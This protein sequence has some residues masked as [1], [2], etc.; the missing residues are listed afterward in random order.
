MRLADH[1]ADAGMELPVV[2]QISWNSPFYWLRAGWRDFKANPLPSLAYG[3][4]FGLGGDLIILALLG[5]PYL[6]TVAVSGLF[7]IAPL[8]AA[9]LY[10]LSRRSARGEKILFIDS[11]R[12]FRRNSQSLA[13]FG[14]LIALLVLVW[15]RLSAIAFSLLGSAGD[16]NT[17]LFLGHVFF[18]GEHTRFVFAWLG[19]GGILALFVF[20]LSVVSVPMMLDRDSDFVTAMLSS[21]YAFMHNPGPLLLWGCII[22]LLTLLGF[23]TLLFGLLLIM[24]ILGHASWHAYRE[25]VE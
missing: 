6:V 9:G 2:R 1:I 12:C 23:A 3:I 5:H 22:V 21:L 13:M 20:A 16:A 8:L 17:L 10:E 24:P 19:L 14:L 7:L 11:I 15:E 4:L 18:S 25:L